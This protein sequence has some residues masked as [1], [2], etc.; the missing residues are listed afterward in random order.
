[1]KDITIKIKGKQNIGKNEEDNIEF[2]TEG[3]YSYRNNS[4]YF[5]YDETEF[6][7]M[8]GTTTILKLTEKENKLKMKRT[9]EFGNTGTELE[10]IAGKRMK[11]LYQ[12][13]YG[14][15]PMEL[16][17]KDINIDFDETKGGKINIDYYICYDNLQEGHN[18]ID[19][20]IK[21]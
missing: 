12:S 19:L 21:F 15:M 2:I 11:I 20:D 18:N 5:V 8:P 6:S 7:G 16:Y 3:R 17:T 4:H 1:M 13:P 10:F 14:K 9:G